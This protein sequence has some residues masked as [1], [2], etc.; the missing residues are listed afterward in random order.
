MWARLERKLQAWLYNLPSS[1][2]DLSQLII[3]YIVD[4]K[5][6]ITCLFLLNRDYI[7]S[8]LK[9]KPASVDLKLQFL[10]EV[11]NKVKSETRFPKECVVA[12][13]T[14]SSW[15][16]HKQ[17][18]SEARE[19]IAPTR[20]RLRATKHSDTEAALLMWFPFIVQLSKSK[21]RNILQE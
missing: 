7:Q 11:D 16:K 8:L 18:L 10:S 19:N 1:N 21:H 20:K 3:D 17:S 9:R 5:R 15:L 2:H 13:S 12:C 6:S 4:S 14:R